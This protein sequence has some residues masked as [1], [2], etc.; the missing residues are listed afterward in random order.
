MNAVYHVG[1]TGFVRL[2]LL[3][4]FALEESWC[5]IISWFDLEPFNYFITFDENIGHDFFR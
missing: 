3:G 2:G 5:K 4:L 1:K